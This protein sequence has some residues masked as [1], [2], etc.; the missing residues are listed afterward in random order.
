MAA[1]DPQVI[2]GGVGFIGGIGAAIGI[3]YT[4]ESQVRGYFHPQLCLYPS[5]LG[6]PTPPLLLHLPSVWWWLDQ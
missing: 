5:S 4:I 3:M 6:Y 2:Q 1:L